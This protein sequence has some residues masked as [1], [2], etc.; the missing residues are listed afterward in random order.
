MPI[1]LPIQ[2]TWDGQPLAPEQHATVELS[3]V[4]ERLL[5][6]IDAPLG[7]DPPPVGDPGPTEALWEHEVV[8]V[9]VVGPDDRYTE[10][11]VGPWGH[12]LVLQLAG[13]RNAVAR[14]LPLA[15]STRVE[16]PRWTAEARLDSGLLPAGP[17]RVNAVAIRRVGGQRLFSAWSPLPGDRP[18]FHQIGSFPPLALA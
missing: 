1:R 6:R 5:I 14:H 15:C 12:H 16:G 18:D 17:H 13:P 4:R 7:E 2:Q 11:E 8:E 9:F 10:I 3:L